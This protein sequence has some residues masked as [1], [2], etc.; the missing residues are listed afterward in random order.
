MS[1]LTKISSLLRK[2]QAFGEVTLGDGTKL[3]ISTEN[4]EIGSDVTAVT[5]AGEAP[6]LAGEYTLSDGTVINVDELGKIIEI[7][8]VKEES[9]DVEV[10]TPVEMAGEVAT[11]VVNPEGVDAKVAE[12]APELDPAKVM[13]ITDSVL[14]LVDEKL[15]TVNTAMEAKFAEVITLMKEMGTSQ[16]KFNED[17]EAF[18]KSP[19][20]TPVSKME[21]SEEGTTDPLTAKVEYIKSLRQK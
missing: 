10:D 20:G 11:D 13:E 16:M 18:K 5:D 4:P 7:S 8:T 1:I 19:A 14:A 9:T 15:A 21:F 3:M 12:I 2:Y 6:A 17:L